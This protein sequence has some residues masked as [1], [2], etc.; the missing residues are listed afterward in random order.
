MHRSVAASP[1]VFFLCFFPRCNV[2]ADI[3]FSQPDGVN[4]PPALDEA[5]TPSAPHLPRSIF[6][7]G[8]F[9]SDVTI[10]EWA[11]TLGFAESHI[12]GRRWPTL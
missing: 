4:C 8:A 2:L 10:S 12:E 1:F 3:V 6:M 9:V 7:F 11:S 5:Q